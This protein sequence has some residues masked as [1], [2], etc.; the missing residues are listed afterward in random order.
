MCSETVNPELEDNYEENIDMEFEPVMEEEEVWGDSQCQ[1]DQEEVQESQQVWQEAGDVIIK[2]GKICDVGNR[3][4]SGPLAR[5]EYQ[6][7]GGEE[8]VRFT[9]LKTES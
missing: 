8:Q 7:V 6:K 1:P 2:D 5:V 9:G 4:G 3:V